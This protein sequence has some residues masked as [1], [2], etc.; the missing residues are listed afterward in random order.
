MATPPPPPSGPT[1]QRRPMA[2]EWQALIVLAI[3]A[4]LAVLVPLVWTM[5]FW[6]GA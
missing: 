1:K 3:L 2:I 4:L 5:L 6:V